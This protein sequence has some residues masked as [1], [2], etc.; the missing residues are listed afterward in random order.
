MT[1]WKKLIVAAAAPLLLTG[2]LWGPGK[3]QST[4]TL[5][6]DGNFTLAYRGEIML[7]RP[8]DLAEGGKPMSW[9]DDL[10]YCFEDGLAMRG[11]P[12]EDIN[13]GDDERKESAKRRDCTPAE[14]ARLKAEHEAAEAKRVAE[15]RKENAQVAEA[16]GLPGFDDQS[17]R[18][19]A[20][21][22][23]RYAGWR[24]VQYRG[25]GIYDVDY[26]L[27]GRTAQDFLFPMMPDSDIVMP[28][29]AIRR[30]ADGA[31]QVTAPMLAGVPGPFGKMAMMGMGKA[32]K[33]APPTKAEGRFTIVTD[34]EILTN[35][36]EDGPSPH[37]AGRQIVWD[38]TT[39]SHKAP[40]ALVRLR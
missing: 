26:Y 36:S 16:L 6:N 13:E 1:V 20:A 29:I 22:L 4:L 18:A 12:P 7:Q 2:C 38:V 28:F 40:E 32:G 33:N 39:D 9:S 3:F 21:K 31:V 19:F 35:N 8:G 30:R 17:N 10:A 27:E 15:K 23:S 37:A 34:G 14:I 11:S 24:S 5:R 25:Q